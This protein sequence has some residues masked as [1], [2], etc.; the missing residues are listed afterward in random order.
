MNVYGNQ[1]VDVNT[2][3]WWVMRFSRG[4]IDVKDKPCLGQPCRFL[5]V[6]HAGSFPLLAKCIVNGDEDL[7]YQVVL[8][9]TL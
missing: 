5:L 4:D 8:L 6:Q 9:C 7:L 1:A 3:R 2:V